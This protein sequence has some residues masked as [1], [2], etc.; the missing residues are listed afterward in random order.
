MTITAQEVPGN[1]SKKLDF[2]W[3]NREFTKVQQRNIQCRLNKKVKMLLGTE[4]SILQAK[5]VHIPSQQL[6]SKI[7]ATQH[8]C[9]LAIRTQNALRQLPLVIMIHLLRLRQQKR[10]RPEES[11]TI[12]FF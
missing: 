10:N 4:L 12:W 11:R 8:C 5:G 9:K 7:A 3:D 1:L 6:Y 2:L